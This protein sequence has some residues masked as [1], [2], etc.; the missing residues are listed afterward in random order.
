MPTGKK[1][2][3]GFIASVSEKNKSKIKALAKALT[4]DGIKVEKVSTM[5]GYI[6]GKANT[7]LE[8][9]KKKYKPKGLDI[10][11]DREVSI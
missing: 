8:E 2:P 9:M 3:T 1:K 10:E 4:K 11:M 7:S 6:S 5:L